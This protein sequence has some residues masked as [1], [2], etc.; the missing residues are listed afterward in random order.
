[1]TQVIV[2]HAAVGR[3]FDSVGPIFLVDLVIFFVSG[4]V[5]KAMMLSGPCFLG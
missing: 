3:A 5:G 4:F 2:S 1:V